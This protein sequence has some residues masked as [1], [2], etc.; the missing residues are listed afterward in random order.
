MSLADDIRTIASAQLFDALE[1]EQLRLLAFGAERLFFKQGRTIF[2][3]GEMATCGYVI[4]SGEVEL[5]LTNG[6]EQQV[7]KTV[8]PSDI[9]GEI[10][11]IT[12]TTRLTGAIAKSDCDVIRITR[13]H[14]RRMLSEYP[15]TAIQ[16]QGELSARLHDFLHDIGQ[17]DIY[18]NEDKDI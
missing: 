3:E 14:F 12:D 18:F 15:Q 11:M 17:L 7:V 1:E 9:L 13:S 16:I 8:G 2:H 5:L 10:A 4:A 6:T